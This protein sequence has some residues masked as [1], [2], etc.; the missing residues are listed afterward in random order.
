MK[1]TYKIFRSFLNG[2][3]IRINIISILALLVVFILTNAC[4]NFVEVDL[5]GSQLIGETVFED[6]TTANAAMA[7]VYT[8]LRDTGLLTGRSTGLS[9][10]L[11]LYSDE[12]DYYQANDPNYFY[13]NSLFSAESGI[14]DLWNQSYNAIYAANA[15]IEGVSASQLLSKNDKDQLKGEALFVRTLIHFYL[16]NLY[17]EI[18]YIKTTDY[19][20][21]SK[22][23][24]IPASE[25][26]NQI[27][28]DV[29][30]AILLLPEDYITSERVRPNK[31]AAHALLAR[32]Y[33]FMG[34][35][36]EAA[37]SASAVL[38]NPLY[39]WEPDL[40]K[41]F[42]KG[43][44]TTIWQF[45]PD[46]DTA[47]SAEG[48]LFIFNS[49]PPETVALNSNLISSFENNDQRK[50]HWARAITDGNSTW[51]HA[52]KYKLDAGAGISSEYSVV[53]RLAEQ[54]L[55]RAEARARQGDL[56]GA[57][58]D[59]NKIRNTAGLPDTDALSSS[60]I[61]VAVLNERRFEFFTEFGHRFFDLKRAGSLDTALALKPGWSHNDALWPLPAQELQANPNLNPQ[62]PGY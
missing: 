17:G 39:T 10:R 23:H 6:V 61:T 28:N 47:N 52:Y 31:A 13:T 24:K 36:P 62:N 59:L 4:D 14:Q 21:N 43:S 49:G 11:G 16:L 34:L 37:N 57:K 44:K 56:I 30:E 48:N 32:V 18:P 3:R 15:I 8:K 33:L 42:L 46:S 41:I 55:I 45:M 25:L 5:P 38:N 2:K 19:A 1:T 60:E 26:Y 27:V 9:C 54:Y 7:G 35:W 20:Q 29:S 51:Y 22:V 40:D 53:F 12:L 58:E 50:T